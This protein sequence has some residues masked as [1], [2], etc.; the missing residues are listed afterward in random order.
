MSNQTKK[1]W[2]ATALCALSLLLLSGCGKQTAEPQTQTGWVATFNPNDRAQS[3]IQV[4]AD[5][6]G[7]VAQPEN[8]TRADYVFTGWYDNKRCAGEP[9][10]FTQALQDDV[11]LYAGWNTSKIRITVDFGI[12]DVQPQTLS[13]ES[14]TVL[15]ESDL[16]AV[17]A[18][19][20]ST[21]AGWYLDSAGAVPVDFSQ[22]F[23]KNTTLYAR[24]QKTKVTVRFDLGYFGAENPADQVIDLTA[25]ETVQLPAEP[26]RGDKGDYQFDGWYLGTGKNREAYDFG[27][28]PTDDMTLYAGWTQLRATVTYDLGDGTA[29]TEKVKL[30]KT[31][32]KYDR[33]E[34]EGFTFNGWFYDPECTHAADMAQLEITG[35][36]TVYASW[37]GLPKTVIYDYN[38]EGAPEPV[39]VEAAY[40][41][42]MTEPEEPTRDGLEFTGWYTDKRCKKPFTF[43]SPIT[44]DLK[45]YAGWGEKGAEGQQNSCLITFYCNDGTD[46]VYKTEEVARNKYSEMRTAGVTYPEREG[47]QAFGWYTTPDCQE[48]T[49]F[50]PNSR[51]KDNLNLYVQWQKE[52]VFEAELTQL[53]DIPIGDTGKVEDKLGFGESSNP[54]GL[55]LIEW[56][57]YDAG[58]SNDYYVSYLYNPGSYLEFCITSSKEVTGA[59]LVL[60]LTPELHDMYFLTG[61]PDG[62]A[63]EKNGYKVYVNPVYS[64]NS[65]INKEQLESYDQ[66][67]SLNAD[68]TGA[69]TKDQDPNYSTKRAFED[70]TIT[71]ELN[72]HEGE[73][74]IRLVTDN[75]HDYG[76]SMHAAAPMVDCIK[77]YTD[78]TLTWTPGH[79]YT[80]NL[81]GIDAR[82]PAKQAEDKETSE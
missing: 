42:V 75:T 29:E 21:F 79:E 26:T 40:G 12:A 50:D 28:V 15:Q 55:Y 36:L 27:T 16:T 58:A 63:A 65:V 82:W 18:P 59:T 69:V 23:T 74:I 68:L 66:V 35:D 17:S 78:A 80:S 45:L 11:F 43:G 34:R 9:F 32:R 54:K 33:F 44:E 38:Y 13:I 52:Y 4:T 53:T 57:C 41:T 19:E 7:H 67:F 46:A 10:D 6:T 37:T 62:T 22:P 48:G 76:G 47:Y 73:N 5:E 61:G 72:L 64:F 81:D 3:I 71:T 25:G 31:A 49:R 24:W 1:A 60:R 39:T 14:G 56:D 2:K 20:N 30:G 8:P 70:Y 51:I 77:I